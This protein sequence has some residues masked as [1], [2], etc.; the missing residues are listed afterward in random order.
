MKYRIYT[1]DCNRIKRE[2][3]WFGND[4]RVMFRQ[5]RLNYYGKKRKPIAK[6]F[7]IKMKLL[8]ALHNSRF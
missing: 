7:I 1:H 2:T 5:Y 6:E 8:N 3:T 4:E